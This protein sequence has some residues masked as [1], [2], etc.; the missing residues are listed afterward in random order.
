[1]VPQVVY[2]HGELTLYL[3]ALYNTVLLY[4]FQQIAHHHCWTATAADV[5]GTVSYRAERDARPI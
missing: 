3:I 4:L 1:M 2:C 5:T